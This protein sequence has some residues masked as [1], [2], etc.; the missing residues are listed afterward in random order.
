MHVAQYI[1]GLSLS[2]ILSVAHATDL[3]IGSL[4]L[5]L[6]MDQSTVMKELHERFHVI[7]VTGKNMFFVS[8]SKP[9]NVHMIGGVSFENGRLSWIQRNWGSF[10]G[11]INPVAVSKALF[12]AIE[13]ART[14]SGGSAAVSTSVQRIP[15]A[16]FKSIYFTFPSRKITVSTTDG[17]EKYGQL[18]SIDESVSVKP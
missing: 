1:T 10:S 17:D 9:P 14:S 11:Q 16:E 5:S 6:G 8:E 3:P 7:P 2:L 4:S 15:G 13:S 12:S 18:V